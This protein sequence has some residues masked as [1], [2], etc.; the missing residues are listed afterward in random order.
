M[1]AERRLWGLQGGSIWCKVLTVMIIGILHLLTLLAL[2]ER[3]PHFVPGTGVGQPQ[4][5]SGYQNPTAPPAGE[6]V[7][8]TGKA[9]KMRCRWETTAVLN[10]PHSFLFVLTAERQKCEVGWEPYEGPAGERAPHSPH[11]QTCCTVEVRLSLWTCVLL[12]KPEFEASIWAL[13]QLLSALSWNYRC[14]RSFPV[15]SV[16]SL[17]GRYFL[18][19]HTCNQT[20]IHTGRKHK[21]S[22]F[23]P[24]CSADICR[25]FR[26]C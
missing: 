24:N 23:V 18:L 15:W 2:T 1:R 22:R 4:S 16:P 20:Q 8:G 21:K 11:G 17:G 7:D 3:L 9:G 13:F 25:S 14:T 19:N 5:G 26:L 6:E 12:W 10:C